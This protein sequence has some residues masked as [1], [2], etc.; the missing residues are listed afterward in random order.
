MKHTGLTG[1]Q[2][3]LIALVT[4]TVD[5]IGV[6]LLP[7]VTLLRIIGRLAFPIFAYMI[8]E[9][10]RYT[11]NRKKYLLSML[12]LAAVCQVVYFFAMGSLYLSVLVTF[13]LSIGLIYLLDRFDPQERGSQ[14]GFFLG[15]CGV[16]FLTR[17][18]PDLIPRTDYG[19]DYG[20][21]GVLLPVLVYFGRSKEEKLRNFTLGQVLLALGSG[22]LQWFSLAIVPLLALYN[23]KRGKRKMKYLFYIYYPAHLVVIYL[24]SLL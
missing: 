2:L 16:F 23:G 15:L 18:L 17:V 10:C 9:G 13:T 3:K 12:G 5:H 14:L 7:R 21:W 20:L 11:H 4:M 1:N 6:S 19:I 8:A 22:P 24:L